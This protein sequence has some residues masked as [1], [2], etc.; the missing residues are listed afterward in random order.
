[1]IRK[2]R[3]ILL[4]HVRYTDNS[5]VAHFY[6]R[7]FGRL[8]VMVKGVSKTKGSSRY[9]YFQPLHMFDLEIYHRENREMH[10]L[11]E[12]TLCYVPRNIPGDIRRSSIALFM[13]E[14]LNNIIREE[15]VNLSLYSFIE[16]S[17]ISLDEAEEGLS[18]FHLWFLAALAAYAGIGPSPMSGD[19]KY[20]DMQTGRFTELPPGHTDI[21]EPPGATLFNCLL[22]STPDVLGR[23]RISGEERSDMLMQIIRF[24]QLH[25]PGVRQVRS[26]QVLK[27]IFR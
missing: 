1:M 10:N 8:S 11:K 22:E 17:V 13:G 3:A 26:L 12:M 19:E 7:E 20:F 15:D 9:L 6:T 27:E 5:L 25:L 23:I 4:H 18:N 24:Y 2:T 14:V 16:S 21:L